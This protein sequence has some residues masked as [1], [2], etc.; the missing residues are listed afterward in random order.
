MVARRREL[1]KSWCSAK[2]GTSLKQS[3]EHLELVGVNCGPEQ[4]LGPRHIGV[5]IVVEQQCKQIVSLCVQSLEQRSFSMLVLLVGI[6]VVY[7]WKS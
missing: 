6:S 5:S 3:L 2:V 4:D 7:L 1:Q